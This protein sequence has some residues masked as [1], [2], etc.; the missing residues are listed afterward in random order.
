MEPPRAATT[1]GR[2]AA[3]RRKHARRSSSRAPTTPL[4]SMLG[5]S[6]SLGRPE[7]TAGRLRSAEQPPAVHGG[8]SC[9]DRT[10]T[11]TKSSPGSLSRLHLSCHTQAPSA[12]END[13]K[14]QRL[15]RPQAAVQASA[16]LFAGRPP[17]TQ[18]SAQADCGAW[19]ASE[20]T[21]DSVE[22]INARWWP[23]GRDSRCLGVVFVCCVWFW[24]GGCGV[25]V[26]VG[27]SVSSEL[28]A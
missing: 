5:V 28:I 6:H 22:D 23:A 24:G 8:A 12:R 21:P 10:S 19:Q 4:S 3:R 13:A 15:Q 27:P 14:L 11:V 9:S 18:A 25:C 26:R 7:S 2:S 20:Q 1:T 16:L 17:A